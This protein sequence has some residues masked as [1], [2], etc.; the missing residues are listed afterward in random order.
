M[1]DANTASADYSPHVPAAVRAQA[2]RAEELLRQ[3]NAGPE[4][5]ADQPPPENPQPEQSDPQPQPQQPAAEEKQQEH[6]PGPRAQ[7]DEW[8]QRY[9]TLQGKY[10]AEV[11]Q[12]QQQVRGLEQLVASMRAQP[13]QP[14]QSYD[15]RPSGATEK[16][17]T[18]YGQELIDATGRWVQPMVEARVRQIEQAYEQRLAQLQNSFQAQQVDSA[19]N[20]VH[21]ALDNDPQL[22]DHW[23]RV[24]TSDGFTRWLQDVDPWSGQLRH[25][26]LKGAYDAGDGPRVAHI[27]RAY[28]AEQTALRPPPAPPAPQTPPSNG[29]GKPSLEQFAAPGRAMGD[30]SGSAPAP[31]RTWTGSE[32]Q[33]FYNAKTRGMYRGRE[34]EADRIEADIIAAPL[35]GRVIG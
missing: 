31:P 28:I 13:P 9:F 18:E 35:Q 6:E 26:L 2:T 24:N 21:Y 30:A 15:S 17:V 16:D 10:N 4:K 14:A 22:R 7:T 33:A 27:F 5:P 34:A 19:H 12:L 29:A 1:P 8:E 32:I 3:Y 11:P 20:R 25:A 23:Q